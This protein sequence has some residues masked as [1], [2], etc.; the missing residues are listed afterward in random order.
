MEITA[1]VLGVLFII[2]ALIVGIKN[3]PQM[4]KSS[5]PVWF[6]SVLMQWFGTAF[7]L[8]ATMCFLKCYE[9]K[10]VYSNKRRIEIMKAVSMETGY[11]NS[12]LAVAM[13]TMS[14]P[15]E[16]PEQVATMWKV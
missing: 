10:E 5:W 1:S 12:T 11:Q 14:F 9:K 7:G 15:L 8:A 13:I 16:T 4:F 3:N 6:T 2:A